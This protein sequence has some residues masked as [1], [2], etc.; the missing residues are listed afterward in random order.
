M[1]LYAW[2]AFTLASLPRFPHL[3]CTAA[4]PSYL[5]H[6]IPVDALPQPASM[7][8]LISQAGVST[9]YSRLTRPD[10]FSNAGEHA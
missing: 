3:C 9:A 5:T 2:V 1:F 4:L 10:S 6:T 7:L 8:E